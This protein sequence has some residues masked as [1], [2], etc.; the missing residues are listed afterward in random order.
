MS[1]GTFYLCFYFRVRYFSRAIKIRT[2]ASP[3]V[4]EN[5]RNSSD[6]S[7]LPAKKWEKVEELSSRQGCR[8]DAVTKIDKIYE[9]KNLTH[10][11]INGANCSDNWKILKN[12][13]KSFSA[14]DKYFFNVERFE[15][16]L[17][18]LLFLLNRLEEN[19]ECRSKRKKERKHYL[20]S[21]TF[22]EWK[23]PRTIRLLPPLS[24]FCRANSC[25]S[26]LQ[27]WKSL[28]NRKSKEEHA[29]LATFS[30]PWTSSRQTFS[31]RRNSRGNFIS[32][33][34]SPLRSSPLFAWQTDRVELHFFKL[35]QSV[36]LTLNGI[37]SREIYKYA[38][39]RAHAKLLFSFLLI[40]YSIGKAR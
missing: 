17:P 24:N 35:R 22:K 16:L 12:I 19:V 30:F 32:I 40:K 10:S 23:Q 26:K 1:R 34:S 5:F 15:W 20:T 39:T 4:A 21:T 18:P 29:T 25:E 28:R 11:E 3:R 36:A 38:H 33:L 14:F 31:F 8:R 6:A 9:K 2:K 37:I 13:W 7:N 27:A